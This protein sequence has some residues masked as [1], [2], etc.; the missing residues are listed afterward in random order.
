VQRTF[1]CAETQHASLTADK[2]LNNL[3]YGLP[4]YVIVHR[5][6]KLLKQCSFLDL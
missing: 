5:N 1:I 2:E 3:I 6:C 4:F